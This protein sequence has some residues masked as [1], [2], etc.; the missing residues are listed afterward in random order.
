MSKAMRADAMVHPVRDAIRN[1]SNP[2]HFMVVQRVPAIVKILRGE[3]VLAETTSALR[4]IEIGDG[5][6]PPVLYIPWQDVKV[7]LTSLLK[8]TFCPLKGDARYFT[9]DS[10]EIGWAYNT[11]DFADVLQGHIAFM[12]D[13]VTVVEKPV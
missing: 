13:K 7:E 5:A 10:E 2:H 1:P 3:T 9:F 6:Y 8:T 11:F 12:V 4:V